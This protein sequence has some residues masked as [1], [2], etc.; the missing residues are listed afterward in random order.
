[1]ALRIEDYALIGDCE[2]AALVGRNGSIDWLCWPRFDSAAFLAALLGTAEHGRWLL[3]PADTDARCRRR[4]REGTVILETQWDTADGSV[5]VTDFMPVREGPPHL[6]RLVRGLSGEV[7]LRTELVLRFDYG[8]IVPWVTRLADGAGLRAIAGPDMVLLRSAVPLRGENLHSVAEFPVRSGEQIAFVLSH[9]ASHEPDPVM[10]QPEAALVQTEAFWT[11]WS[12][13]CSHTGEW[14]E[15]VLRSHITLK[16]L[17]YAPTGAIVAAPTT[18]LPEQHRGTRNWDY[19]YCWLRDAT[20]TLLSLMDADYEEEALAWREWLLRA[21]AGTPA[22]AQIMYGIGGERRL[23][24]WEVPWLPGYEGARPVRVGNAAHG[25]L[26]LDVYGEVADALHQARCAGLGDPHAGWALERALIQHLGT[27]WEQPDEGIWEVRGG[28]RHFTHSKVMAWLAVDR[29]VRSAQRFGLPAPLQD[30]IALRQRIHED[31]CRRGYA[32]HLGSFV[33]SYDSH[34]LDASLLL[35]PLVGFLP[36]SDVRVRGT[37]AAIE[38]QLLR[39]GLVLR[40]DT[41]ETQDGLPPGEGAFLACSFWFVDNLVLQGRHADARA[42]FERLLLLRN[43]V[44]LLAEEYDPV[45]RRQLGNFP[46]A[47]SHLAL[48]DTARNLGSASKP[49]LR[50]PGAAG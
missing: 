21:V 2:S 31:V 42:M 41:A 24:E 11:Q 27:V 39:D 20:F 45:A 6:V 5:I 16:A 15:A 10:L 4:Y 9:S 23:A 25:Q 17:T 47:F 18:S 1:M 44:G 30:W 50:R 26:Q 22:S 13:R 37:F 38:R 3:A 49:A 29:A 7:R 40:Y 35:I 32:P 43:D 33:Q 8:S 34:A 19:R 46:Q 36:A 48:A 12:S 14:H 28:N